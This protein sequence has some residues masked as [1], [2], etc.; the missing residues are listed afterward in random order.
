MTMFIY[1]YMWC[2][3]LT[4]AMA[5]HGDICMGPSEEI[6]LL[7]DFFFS[8]SFFEGWDGWV[9][10]LIVFLFLVCF[11]LYVLLFILLM[12]WLILACSECAP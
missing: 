6:C 11:L 3:I 5:T 2:H 4:V 10:L 1:W 8:F 9:F 12:L 7:L